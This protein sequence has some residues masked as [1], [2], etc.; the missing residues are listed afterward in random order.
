[1][2]AERPAVPEWPGMSSKRCMENRH[3]A[4]SL[5]RSVFK[6]S[7]FASTFTACVCYHSVHACAGRRELR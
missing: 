5:P 6:Q 2:L 7:Y 4:L 1:M 3:T